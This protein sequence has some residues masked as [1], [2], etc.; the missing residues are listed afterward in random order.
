MSHKGNG[1]ENIF[2]E[3]AAYY[4]ILYQDKDYAGEALF[5]ISIN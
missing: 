1:A 5:Y 4:D 2:S 3:Y